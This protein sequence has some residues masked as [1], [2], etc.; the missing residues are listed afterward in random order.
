MKPGDRVMVFDHLL[1]VD[2]V[3]TPLSY[4]MRSAII[5]RKYWYADV[6]DEGHFREVVDVIFM[7]RPNQFS[8]AQFT[9]F[10]KQLS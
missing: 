7:H 1:F 6:S 8:K 5:V 3:T 4:T 2:D 9:P 10:V